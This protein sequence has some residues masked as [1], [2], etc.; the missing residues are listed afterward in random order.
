[1][2]DN[3]TSEKQID[4]EI[5]QSKKK[6]NIWIGISV[7]FLIISIILSVAVFAIINKVN[8]NSDKGNAMPLA[9]EFED[10]KES[11]AADDKVR[12]LIDGVYVESGRENHYPAAFMIDNHPAARPSA[13]LSKASLVYEAEAEG[14]TTRFMA[15]F[16][17][18]EDLGEIGS[19]RSARPYYID[20]AKEIPALYV[21]VGGSP[22]ALAKI[23]KEKVLNLNEFYQGNYF[24][25]SKEKSA[26]YNVYTS[27]EKINKY[28]ELKN[29]NESAFDPWLFKEDADMENRGDVASLKVG[30]VL[31]GFDVE[32]RYDVENNDFL[33]LMGGL[34]H[35]DKQGDLIKAKNIVIQYVASEAID[36]ALRLEMKHIG[37][38]KALVCLDGACQEGEWRKADAK[39][40]TRFYDDGGNEIKFNAGPTWIEVIPPQYRVAI[41]L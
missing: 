24:W 1:M 21:H 18:G 31:K 25:R 14:G 10:N 30:F 29:P 7:I 40:R 15:V 22:A 17:N 13:S 23:A 12:R 34:R 9:G 2:G 41:T 11:V 5:N 36:D 8:K 27:S 33:R 37:K 16:A 4:S 38:G 35:K 6:L 3:K 39:S 20:W 26:P 32:W 19:I 28:L